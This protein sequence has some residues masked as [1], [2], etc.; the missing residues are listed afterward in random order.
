V[1]VFYGH[2]E[3]KYACQHHDVDT[4]HIAERRVSVS[5][6]ITRS[7][8]EMTASQHVD[9]SNPVM[10]LGVASMLYP[11]LF[12]KLSNPALLMQRRGAPYQ[13]YNS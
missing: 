6:R 13:R 2:A 1:L 12:K 5:K 8:A 9:I 3:H 11:P 10:S 4:T 7:K